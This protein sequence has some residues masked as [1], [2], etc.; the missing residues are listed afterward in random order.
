MD[1]SKATIKKNTK[2]KIKAEFDRSPLKERL[3]ARF[4]NFYFL[5]GIGIKIFRFIFLVGIAYIVLFPFFTKIA[6]SFM[7]PEDFTDVTVRLIPKNFSLDIYKAVWVDRDYV[8][9]LS[10]TVLVSALVSVLQT[11]VCCVLAYGIAKYK[12]KGNNLIFMVVMLTMIIPHRTIGS[13]MQLAFKNFDLFGIFGFLEGGG[14]NFLGLKFNNEALSAINVFPDKT[15]GDINFRDMFTADGINLLNTYFPFILLS[16]TGL[17]FKNGLYIFLLRQFFMGVPDELEESAY[18]DGSGVFRTFFTIIL[19]IS[20]PMMITVFL[21]SFS[22]CWTDNFYT[23]GTM[24]FVSE[25]KAPYLLTTFITKVQASPP[26][27]L[28]PSN[29][30]FQKI[31]E[32]QAAINNTAGLMTIAPLVVMYMFCQKYLVQGIE[33]S[34]LTA[35]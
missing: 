3:K 22:W 12:F 9:A 14:I 18:I 7:S 21:F 15:I 27:T 10:N 11:F 28:L 34:G 16:L 26:V 6:G 17:A 13:A 8:Q 20:I 33:R 30:G 1:N 29:S 35:D 32:Y 4:V 23:G 31:A 5:S 2:R 24:F 19:P 25:T